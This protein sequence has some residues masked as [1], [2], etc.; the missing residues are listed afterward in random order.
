MEEQGSDGITTPLHAPLHAK[1]IVLATYGKVAG[2]FARD[3][4]RLH[5]ACRRTNKRKLSRK[6]ASVND[7]L[8]TPVE[9]LVETAC[10]SGKGLAGASPSPRH[11]IF[12]FLLASSG[13]LFLVRIMP[14]SLPN[15][16]TALSASPPSAHPPL[17]CP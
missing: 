1:H 3:C 2:H 13:M 7:L 6:A 14:S 11:F 10:H 5:S 15:Y 4:T 17:A 8:R 12:P 16:K 9:S